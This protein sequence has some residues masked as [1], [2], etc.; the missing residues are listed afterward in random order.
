MYKF[1]QSSVEEL[2]AKMVEKV[3][4]IMGFHFFW[5]NWSAATCETDGNLQ[6]NKNLRR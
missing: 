3:R 5:D 4:D 1:F 2:E 6:K